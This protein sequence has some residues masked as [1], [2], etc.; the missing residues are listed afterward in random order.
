[1]QEAEPYLLHGTILP[2]RAR[3]SH[4]FWLNFKHTGSGVEGRVEISIVHNQMAIRV[5]TEANWDLLDLRNLAATVVRDEL[6][7][8][9]YLIGFAFDF[10]ITRVLNLSRGVDYVFGIDVPCIAEPRKGIDI[11]CELPKL[12]RLRSG[13]PGVYISRCFSD[14]NS[15]LRH[16]DDLP[17]YCYRALESLRKHCAAVNEL[18]EGNGAAAWKKFRECSNTSEEEIRFISN[19]AKELRHG[20]TSSFDGH[21]SKEM[22]E[23]TWSIVDRYIA[24]LD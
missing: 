12:R 19:A 17:F 2:E 24:S 20:G 7:A 14:L 15:A 13:E 4:F 22:L 8:I 9:G 10:E 3:L 11:N 6:S 23:R 16:I 1:M 21:F 18:K 5:F